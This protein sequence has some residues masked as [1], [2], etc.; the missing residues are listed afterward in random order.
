MK[1]PTA[2]VALVRLLK[3]GDESAGAAELGRL[4]FARG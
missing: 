2:A 1:L 4:I 3:V